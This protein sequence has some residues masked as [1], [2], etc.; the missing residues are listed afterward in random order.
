MTVIAPSDRAVYALGHSARELERLIAQAR[1]VDPITRRFFEE[2]GIAPGMRVL[3][4]GSGAGDVA[5]LAAD[6]VGRTGEVIGVERAPAAL[7]VARA[8]AEAQ[9]RSNVSF[10]E[11]DPTTMRFEQPFDAVVGR[12]VL[13]YYPDPAEA[14]RRLASHLRPGGLLVFHETDWS[15][16]RSYPPSPTYDRCCQWF[17]DTFKA[18][19]TETRMGI[20]LHSAFVAADLPAPTTRLQAIIGGDTRCADW[21]RILAEIVAVLLPDMERLGIA[22]A[23]EIGIDTLVDRLCAEVAAGGGVVVGRAEIGAWAAI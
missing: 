17:L 2:A 14:L 12:L 1:L 4:V 19:G 6:L 13:M 16:V 22:T 10:R 15:E 11:G 21:L 9:V 23:A 3:D 8:R 7:K 5:F 18:L 20:K